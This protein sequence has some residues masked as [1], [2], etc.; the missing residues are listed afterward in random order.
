M[1]ITYE[2]WGQYRLPALATNI[3]MFEHTVGVAPLALAH[4]C[5][6]DTAVRRLNFD[7]AKWGGS[8]LSLLT[9]FRLFD[10]I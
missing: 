5:V 6:I 10:L 7:M 1:S 8:V 3:D 9:F 4:W 2:L